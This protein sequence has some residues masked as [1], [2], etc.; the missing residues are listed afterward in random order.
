MRLAAQTADYSPKRE[1]RGVWVAT[2]GNIDW[3]SKQALTTEQQKNELTAIFDDQQRTGMNVIVFQV[4]PAA[5]AF[6]AK[7][8][9]PWSR[10]LTGKP[11]KA[12]DPFYDPL[13][14]AIT[15][16][17]KRGM[18]LHAWFN[19]YRATVDLL[20]THTSADHITQTRPGWFFTYDGRK[21]FNPGI[22]QVRDY[23][24]QVILDVLRNY[25]VDGIHFDDYFYPYKDRYNTPIPDKVT[26]EA[27][28]KGFSDIRDWRRQNVDTLIHVLSDSIR[29]T[30]PF[31]KFGISPFGIWKNYGQDTLGSKSA[32]GSSYLEQFADSRKWVAKGWVDYITPQLY[33]TFGYRPA[34]FENLLEWWSNNTYNRHLYI[35]QGAYRAAELR[36]GWNDR[37]TIPNQLRALR[38]NPRVQGSVFFSSKS[39]INNL[40]GVRDSLRFDFYKFQALVP[41]MLWI[42]PVPPNA[43]GVLVS[44][45]AARRITLNWNVPLKAADGE[46]AYGYVV[47]RFNEGEE[48]NFQNPRNILRVSYDGSTTSYTDESVRPEV[49]YVYAVT[50][51][52]RLKN[53][54]MPTNLVVAEIGKRKE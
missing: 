15:E 4:R 44:S 33:W 50:A 17:H 43:P 38:R 37:K 26:F 11:G 10:Y 2:V 29:A 8:R 16:A 18:E 20:P 32:G 49:R 23:I 13:E 41:P 36:Y 39:V 46:T 53:E 5:D 19:P 7:G 14:F 24:V 21:Q 1:F 45:V 22:P 51:L 9:E 25:D 3:P 12:P 54:S 31:V 35:G 28:G 48:V 47:Y 52:D 40:G 27:F 30:K 42:D 6:Y 34:P